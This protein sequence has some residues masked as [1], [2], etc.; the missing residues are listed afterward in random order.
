MAAAT[1]LLG[2]HM[3]THA[4]KACPFPPELLAQARAVATAG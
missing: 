3:D 2:V 4:R 1:T